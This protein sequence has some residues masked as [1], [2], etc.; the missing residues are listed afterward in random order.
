MD[1]ILEYR[2]FVSDIATNAESR[3]F[4]NS[5]EEHGLIVYLNLFKIANEHVRIFA[6][7]L[8]EHIGNKSEFV[9]AISE[10]IERGGKVSLLLNNY[11]EEAIVKSPLFMRLAYYASEKKDV[12]VKMTEVS[13]TLGENRQVHFAIADDIAYRLETN[14]QERTALCNFNNATVA[15]KLIS[16]FDTIFTSDEYSHTIDLIK[17]FAYDIE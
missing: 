6:G 2:K 9:E 15:K 16:V 12:T 4:L 3:T 7:N 8:C 17:L 1:S 13:A 10:F 14:V 5:D 11:D